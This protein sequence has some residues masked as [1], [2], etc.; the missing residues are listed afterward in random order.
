MDYQKVSLSACKKHV[1]I[2]NAT[3]KYEL[4][5]SRMYLKSYQNGNFLKLDLIKNIWSS[6]RCLKKERKN[7]ENAENA[8][9]HLNKQWPQKRQWFCHGGLNKEIASKIKIPFTLSLTP[10]PIIS[11]ALL[12]SEITLRLST[13]LGG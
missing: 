4:I 5:N 10:N 9:K 1:S 2:G 11:S 6:S 7:A 3:N 12:S 13:L 8:K